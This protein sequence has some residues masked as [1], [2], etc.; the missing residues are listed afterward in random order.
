MR[1]LIVDDNEPIRSALAR[2][3]RPHVTVVVGSVAE[4]RAALD[5]EDFDLI[6]SDIMMPKET[7]VALH[8]W[9]S[10]MYPHL[11]ARFIFITGGGL[12]PR[13]RDYVKQCGA[14][15]LTKPFD[16]DS[17]LRAVER[18]AAGLTIGEDGLT[19][20]SS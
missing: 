16:T 1:I 7:G 3:L 6:L 8:L 10:K 9:L 14:P 20:N 11:T 4:A 13:V 15:V 17:V 2:M 19:G 12:P 5:R 18:L